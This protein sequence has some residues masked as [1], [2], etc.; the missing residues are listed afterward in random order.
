MEIS[1]DAD[2]MFRIVYKDFLHRRKQQIPKNTARRFSDDY[3]Q[4]HKKFSH[5]AE[6]DLDRTLIEL[7]KVGYVKI[8]IG[9][10]FDLTDSGIVYMENRS[11][12]NLLKFAD[13]VSKFIP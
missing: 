13:L 8:F 6:S 2:R 4:S 1:R 9:G 12:T 7:S 5:W 11:K 10:N 3:F